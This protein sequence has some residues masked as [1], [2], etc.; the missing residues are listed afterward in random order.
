MHVLNELSHGYR[1][2]RSF[3]AHKFQQIGLVIRFQKL[4][5]ARSIDFPSLIIHMSFSA[6]VGDLAYTMDKYKE[7][8]YCII[9]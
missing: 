4:L 2:S 9:Q 5:L 6:K 7:N 3:I 8:V 1:L